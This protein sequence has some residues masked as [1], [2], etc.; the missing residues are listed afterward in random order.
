MYIMYSYNFFLR[1][2]LCL[3]QFLMLKKRI[4]IADRRSYLHFLIEM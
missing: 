1:T 3:T 2:Y 4:I